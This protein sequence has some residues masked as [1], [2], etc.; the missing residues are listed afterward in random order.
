M[1]LAIGPFGDL[2]DHHG[3]ALDHRQCAA[4]SSR[5][6]SRLVSLGRMLASAS[7]GAFC[8]PGRVKKSKVG[9]ER[10]VSDP[11]SR[12]SESESAGEPGR[13]RPVSRD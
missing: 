10:G 3:A 2:P 12:P 8:R 5:E 11:A 9:A 1:Q 4:G 13:S 7:A 6:L